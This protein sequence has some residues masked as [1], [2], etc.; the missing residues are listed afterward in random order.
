MSGNLLEAHTLASS[1]PMC[2]ADDDIAL[3]EGIAVL[4]FVSAAVAAGAAIAAINGF[5]ATVQL[6]T[7][8]QYQDM[9]AHEALHNG[10]RGNCVRLVDAF[11]RAG[12]TQ[13][14]GSSVGNLPEELFAR[15]GMAPQ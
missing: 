1:G 4:R 8:G 5:A 13:T 3:A 14:A 9:R 11:G 15:L 12:L 7:S 2:R 10:S 6:E